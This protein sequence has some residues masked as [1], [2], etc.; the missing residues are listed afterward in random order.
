M[1]SKSFT[2]RKRTRSTT[3]PPTP[4][5]AKID[6]KEVVKIAKKVV[7]RAAETKSSIT[8]YSVSPL[9]GQWNASNLSFYINQGSTAEDVVGEKIFLKSINIRGS[10]FTQNPNAGIP[11]QCRLVLFRTKQN[12]TTGS[13]II[14]SS[15]LVRNPVPTNPVQHHIDLHKVDLLY[16]TT[17]TLTPQVA[18]TQV[19]QKDFVINVPVNKTHYF[20]TD[21]SGLFKDKQY[22]LA[23]VGYN[24]II[25]SSP[26]GF[27]F[28]AALNFKDM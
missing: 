12:L 17:I 3:M 15:D 8:N 25:V 23:V 19:I 20:D 24:G 22:Y 1:E 26:A 11:T 2:P 14:T 13:T 28:T 27:Q 9:D 10:I 7:M 21:T 6:S 4:K 16:D 18:N 5:K